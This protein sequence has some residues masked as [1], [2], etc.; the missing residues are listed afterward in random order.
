MSPHAAIYL[1]WPHGYDLLIAALTCCLVEPIHYSDDGCRDSSAAPCLVEQRRC[2]EHIDGHRASPAR[3]GPARPGS[4][5]VVPLRASC[6]VFVP[7]TALWAVFRVVPVHVARHTS[8]AM[9][10]HGPSPSKYLKQ[11]IILHIHQHSHFTITI[12]HIEHN[13]S[14]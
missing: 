14:R 3:P 6:L 4:G 9:P 12:H 7:G 8:R 5:R 10:A 11:F 1:V 13:T 2:A